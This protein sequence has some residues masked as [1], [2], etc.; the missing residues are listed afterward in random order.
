MR[1]VVAIA[2]LSAVGTLE[3]SGVAL[4]FLPLWK[5]IC[6]QCFNRG[7]TIGLENSMFILLPFKARLVLLW[8]HLRPDCQAIVMIESFFLALVLCVD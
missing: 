5:R 3:S 7:E 2:P 1:V 6:V 8:F 4:F